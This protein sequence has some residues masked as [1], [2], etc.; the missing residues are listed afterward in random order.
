MLR[1]LKQ[2]KSALSLLSPNEVRLRAERPLVV[3]LV[4]QGSAAY[5]DM[6]DFLMPPAVSHDKRTEVMQSVYRACDAGIPKKYDLVL[7]EQGLPCPTTAFTFFRDDPGRTVEEI[8]K[9]R[10]DLGLTLARS[11]YPF[12]KPV[13]DRIIT[14]TARENAIFAV[15]SAL[16]NV[17]PSVLELPWAVGEFA[18]DTAFITMNQVRM[19]FLVAAASDRQVG[20]EK[21]LAELVSI[22]AGAFGWRALARELVGFIPLGGGLIPKGAI[23]FAATYV[24]GKGLEHFHGVGYGYTRAQRKDAYQAAYERGKDVVGAVLRKREA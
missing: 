9:A 2:A 1:Y 16:P 8:V 21:Q 23:A 15:A 14:S 18:S 7:Y 6:E 17:V 11:F 13:V 3:G 19:A 22:A 12:R 5:A 24:L 4:A 10:D 20:Y